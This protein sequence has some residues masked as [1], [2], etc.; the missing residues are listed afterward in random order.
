MTAKYRLKQ[1]IDG[2]LA[3]LKLAQWF[4]FLGKYRI[5]VVSLTTLLGLLS[6]MFSRCDEPQNT[7]PLPEPT[8]A[9]TVI[10]ETPTPMPTSTPTPRPPRIIIDK[11]VVAGKPFRVKYT[12]PFAYNTHLWADEWRLGYM[13][14]DV[15][16]THALNSVL[17]HTGGKR[18]LTIRDN[19]G[20]ILASEDVEVRVN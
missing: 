4:P 5:I 6:G 2:I 20:N 3:L 1:F 19:D 10:E 17:L 12:A 7:K 9:P 14:K 18:R 13:G 11:D 16:G 15:D 8:E